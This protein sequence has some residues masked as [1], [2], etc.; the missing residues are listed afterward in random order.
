MSR[1]N[2]VTLTARRRQEIVLTRVFDAPRRLVYN[3][4]TLPEMLGHWFGPADAELVVCRLE[5][6]R[7]GDFDYLWRHADGTELRMSGKFLE[8]TDPQRI[9]A[10]E[11]FETERGSA[12]F[13]STTELEEANGLTRLTRTI[14][15][16]ASAAIDKPGPVEREAKFGHDRLVNL[17]AIE[18]TGRR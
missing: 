13:V 17:F 2:S 10:L 5:L 16:A 6:R 14:R 18:A 7:G 15:S 1:S 12:E 9:V 8:V 3:A 11:R 4:M